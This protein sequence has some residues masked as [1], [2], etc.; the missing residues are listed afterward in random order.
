MVTPEHRETPSEHIRNALQ[1][2]DG[3]A[4]L[5]PEPG[6]LAA[7][8][9][10][11]PKPWPSDAASEADRI[12]CGK[13]VTLEEVEKITSAVRRRLVDALADL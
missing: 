9:E 12:L 6:D 2:L 11:A 4:I 1:L 10:T 5:T 3:L 8:L 7:L 13:V